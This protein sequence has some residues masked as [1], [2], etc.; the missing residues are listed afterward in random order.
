MRRPSPHRPSHACKTRLSHE[1]PHLHQGMSFDGNAPPSRNFLLTSA[2]GAG[3]VKTSVCADFEGVIPDR[4]YGAGT[5]LVWDRGTFE[6]G[7]GGTAGDQLA[8]GRLSF[9][10]KGEKLR[11]A[12]VLL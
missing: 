8:R 2:S 7:E 9:L 3:A 11:G 1:Q 12:F 6:I 4:Q 10:L 5:M